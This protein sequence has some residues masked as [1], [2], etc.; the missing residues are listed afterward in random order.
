VARFVEV[1]YHYA[2]DHCPE[3]LEKAFSEAKTYVLQRHGGDRK[4]SS[5]D[6]DDSP[7]QYGTSTAYLTARLARDR[8]DI[9]ARLH[10]GEY[11]SVRAAAREAGMVKDPTPLHVLQR[12]WHRASPDERRALVD[13][14]TQQRVED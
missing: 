11:R 12:L 9:L 10:A 14:I 1:A 6:K 2:V 7:P 5:Y 3:L 8:P 13:W 4:S